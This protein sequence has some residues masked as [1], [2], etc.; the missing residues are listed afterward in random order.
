MKAG[1]K[2]R[3]G[4][5]MYV[6]RNNGW[7]SL[8]AFRNWNLR[9]LSH[10]ISFVTK[11]RRVSCDVSTRSVGLDI[12]TAIFL[13]ASPHLAPAF[14]LLKVK[15]KNLSANALPAQQIGCYTMGLLAWLVLCICFALLRV[16]CVESYLCFKKQ[17]MTS[18]GEPDGLSKPRNGGKWEVCTKHWHADLSVSYKCSKYSLAHV[19]PKH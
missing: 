17:K 14:P 10:A 12:C 2:Y 13:L 7:D 16:S 11:N 9:K 6:C 15:K 19:S 18:A 3:S 1:S 5:Y 8:F 4:I